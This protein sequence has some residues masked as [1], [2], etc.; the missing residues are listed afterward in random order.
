[1]RVIRGLDQEQ[2][3]HH[4]AFHRGKAGRHMLR[5]RV[6]LE[7]VLA[8]DVD[9]LE[10]AVER[11]V[12]HVGDAQAGLG[13]EW[14][15]PQRLEHGAGGVVRDVAVAGNLVRERA[16]VARALHVVLPAQGVHADAAPADIAGGHG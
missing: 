3:L 15:A 8:L 6:G 9:A 2:I 16:H 13:V 12:D 4:D 7:N 1:M 11:R 10:R 5:V 14:P